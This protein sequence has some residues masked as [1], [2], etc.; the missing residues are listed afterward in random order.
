VATASL[1]RLYVSELQIFL[2]SMTFLSLTLGAMVSENRRRLKE[3]TAAALQAMETQLVKIRVLMKMR[4][5]LLEPLH[6]LIG[7]AEKGEAADLLPSARELLRRLDEF[8][9]QLEVDSPPLACAGFSGKLLE[10]DF[11]S[12]FGESSLP[13]RPELV[14]KGSAP[15]LVHCDRGQTGEVFRRLLSFLAQAQS[16]YGRRGKLTAEF[17]PGKLFFRAEVRS[18][19]AAFSSQEMRFSGHLPAGGY[20]LTAFIIHSLVRNLGGLFKIF[21]DHLRFQDTLIAEVTLPI[22]ECEGESP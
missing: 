3:A 5:S 16:P 19:S 7:E 17:L 21:P 1:P 6:G 13:Q 18:L 11:R 14:V 4:S 15:R 12:I 10:G 9:K 2:L 20:A 8:G 22:D